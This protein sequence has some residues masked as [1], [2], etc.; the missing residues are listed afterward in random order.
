MTASA[1]AAAGLYAGLNM[2]IMFWLANAIGVLRRGHKIAVGDGGNKHLAKI[3]RGQANAAENMPLFLIMLVVAAATG[4]AE[5]LVHLFGLAFTAG[6]ALHAWHFI[7]PKAPLWQRFAGFGIAGLSTF[8][9]AIWMI[10]A[11]LR[12]AFGG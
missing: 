6:R 11:G 1:L 10:V 4:M 2:L 5:W 3:M 12:A 7:Q 8:I 9:L